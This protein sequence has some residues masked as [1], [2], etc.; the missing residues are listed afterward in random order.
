MTKG[1]IQ[2]DRVILNIHVPK[3]GASELT[4]K[5]LIDIKGY[6]DFNTIIVVSLTLHFEQRKDHL[7]R[8]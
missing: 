8:K 2:Q 7:D 3:I 4:K 6:I 1:L 5:I